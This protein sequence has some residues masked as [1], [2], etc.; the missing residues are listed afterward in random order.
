MLSRLCARRRSVHPYVYGI[1][2]VNMYG[3]AHVESASC[4]ITLKILTF[5]NGTGMRY[6]RLCVPCDHPKSN[7]LDEN[8]SK[9]QTVKARC[10]L[11]DKNKN[12]LN[13]V[14]QPAAAAAAVASGAGGEIAI[15]SATTTAPNRFRSILRET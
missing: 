13:E 6:A 15:E 7:K 12:R 3:M 10:C 8:E 14:I 5:A 11:N 1:A 2:M 4:Q 9:K